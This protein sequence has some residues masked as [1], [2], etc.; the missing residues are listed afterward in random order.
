MGLGLHSAAHYA[1]RPDGISVFCQKGGDY[2]V[3][4]PLAGR[5]AVGMALF[6]I[7]AKAPVLHSDARSGNNNARTETAEVALDI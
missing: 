5:G 4:G 6:Q 7:E 2:S 1:E 3:I